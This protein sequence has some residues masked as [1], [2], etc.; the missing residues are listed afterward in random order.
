MISEGMLD[1]VMSALRAFKPNLASRR[2][3][4]LE[5][6]KLPS[7]DK[8]GVSIGNNAN[9]EVSHGRN[10][11]LAVHSETKSDHRR[12]SG[13][14]FQMTTRTMCDGLA[15]SVEGSSPSA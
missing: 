9:E 15:L 14:L 7:I 10:D 5:R 2:M 11:L 4:I 8:V 6:C 13:C 3:T 1:F 12:A